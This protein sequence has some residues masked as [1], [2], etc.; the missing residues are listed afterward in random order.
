MLVTLEIPDITMAAI[1]MNNATI[2]YGNIVYAASLGCS[3]PKEFEHFK[4][5]DEDKL[6][7]RYQR[8]KSIYEQIED[9]ERVVKLTK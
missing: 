7:K 3:V 9:I 1:A 8:V 5:L 6:M 4:E 2:A